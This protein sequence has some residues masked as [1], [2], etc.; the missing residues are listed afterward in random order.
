MHICEL[1]K[2]VDLAKD[3]TQDMLVE[4]MCCQHLSNFLTTR[5]PICFRLAT[6]YSLANRLSRRRKVKTYKKLGIPLSLQ[7]ILGV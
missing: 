7:E 4:G 6:V 1:Q 2:A 5:N 3:P